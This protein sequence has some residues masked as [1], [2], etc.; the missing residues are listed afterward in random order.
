MPGIASRTLVF[1]AAVAA[2]G[3]ATASVPQVK[4][5]GVSQTQARPSSQ[6]PAKTLL[7]F[8]EVVNPSVRPLQLSRLEYRLAADDWFQAHGAVPLSRAIAADATVVVEVPVALQTAGTVSAG[9]VDYVLEGTLFAR[10]QQVE[11]SWKV[12]V[13]GTLQA[14]TVAGGQV[15]IRVADTPR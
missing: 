3:C 13:R 8:L 11:R 10:D 14:D 15:R 4:V 1:L 5:L 2:A 12:A 7:V 6:E 9:S